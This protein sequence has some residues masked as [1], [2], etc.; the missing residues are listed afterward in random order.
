MF[1]GDSRKSWNTM[2]LLFFC[3]ICKLLFLFPDVC[4]LTFYLQQRGQQFVQI[5]EL[6][7]TFC[8]SGVWIVTVGGKPFK[9]TSTCN[10]CRDFYSRTDDDD[11]DDDDIVY[12]LVK[13]NFF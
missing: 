5:S 3:K 6:T 13:F 9:A 8:W 12:S 2:C 11:D 4:C 10:C 1:Q 7:N